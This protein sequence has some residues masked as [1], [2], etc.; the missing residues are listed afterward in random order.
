MSLQSLS[1]THSRKKSP[2]KFPAGSPEAIALSAGGGVRGK[3]TWWP[4]RSSSATTAWPVPGNSVSVRHV[5]NKPY[6]HQAASARHA[7]RHIPA[8]AQ[9]ARRYIRPRRS[10]ARSASNADPSRPAPYRSGR[11]RPAPPHTPVP[12][13]GRAATP[14]GVSSRRARPPAG[15]VASVATTTLLKAT[16][17]PSPFA[18]VT[19][20]FLVHATRKARPARPE[21]RRPGC[22]SPLGRAPSGP[23]RPD[24]HHHPARAAAASSC[25]TSTPTGVR[26]TATATR[27]P[28]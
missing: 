12:H 19:A 17:S 20:S 3:S 18:L 23:A 27:S 14:C 24:R 6:A 9:R 16:R 2:R 25:S 1:H 26:A 28:E 15:A 13:Q 4:S 22:R 10:Q 21:R 5:T 7:T 11:G 8:A